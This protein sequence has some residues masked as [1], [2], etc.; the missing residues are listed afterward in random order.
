MSK[1]LAVLGVASAAALL[2]VVLLASAA[3]VPAAGAAPGAGVRAAASPAP[4]GCPDLTA[5]RSE[6][7][8]A[9]FLRT[10]R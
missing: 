5:H 8:A 10:E 6:E 4:S 3:A 9:I 2:S 1:R 7:R